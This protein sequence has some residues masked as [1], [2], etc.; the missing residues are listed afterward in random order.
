[1]IRRLVPTAVLA[2]LAFLIAFSFYQG[3][4]R[5]ETDFPNYYT[6]A[7]LVRKGERLR[8]YYDWTYFQRQMNYAGIERQLG[9]YIPQT[10]LTMLPM[11]PISVFAPQSAKRLWLV[12]DLA[13]LG[14]TLWLLSRITRFS[15]WQLAALALA[16]YGSMHIN[17]LLGQYYVFLLF[18]L[19]LA[20]YF[21]HRHQGG[22]AGFFF[23]LTFGLKLYGAPFLLYFAVKRQKKEA[24]GMFVTMLCLAVT[25]VL[26]FGWHD[27]AYFASQILPRALRGETLD[28]YNPGTGTIFTL[29]RRTLVME[30]ELNP[31]PLFDAPE[32]FFFLQ[33]LLVL[34]I[35]GLPLLAAWRLPA[36][37]RDL[38]WF[39]IA[40]LLASPNTASYTFILLL[41]PVAVL[42]M[43]G[44]LTE[45]I[46]LIACYVLLAIPMRPS[47]SW[48]FPKVWLLLVLY[49]VAGL[50]YWRRIQLLPLAACVA[51]AALV[52]LVSA[53]RS[54]AGY[55]Q[56]PGR[57][58][59]RVALQRGAIYSASPAVV[60]SGVVYDSIGSDRYVLRWLHDDRIEMFPFEGH[61]FH[62]IALSADGPVR[63]ELVAHGASTPMLFD[64]KTLKS[65]R[66]PGVVPKE[67][68]ERLVASP[69]GRWLAMT[70]TVSG[71]KQVWVSKTDGTGALRLTGGHC[72][73]FG[74]VWDLDS[75]SLI[76]AS[77]CGRGIGLTALY[78]ARLDNLP[79][80]H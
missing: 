79:D 19:T 31:N 23:G 66:Q 17:F 30:P 32:L 48:L 46:L 77:D 12:C 43:E 75:K 15:I 24:L 53:G 60:R 80:F 2:T 13:F 9:G 28:P 29:L 14:G 64:L 50:H 70:S 34:I 68:E 54:L 51:V 10:P 78:R 44:R 72:N 27:V 61:A 21:L 62:P 38:A 18:L 39:L 20:F 8:N 57:R 26:L 7:V 11:V 25:A 58:W 6:A 5:S 35:L 76:F 45:K 33:P 40:L 71:S 16:G 59:E 67:N 55:Q 56:E 52:A 65:V 41:L 74:P 22:S 1:M 42:L 4:T 63:F 73:S 47:W 69:N 3:W 37:Q 36:T 49:S